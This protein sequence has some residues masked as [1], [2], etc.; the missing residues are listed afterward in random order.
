MGAVRIAAVLMAVSGLATPLPAQDVPDR[1]LPELDYQADRHDD[2]ETLEDEAADYDGRPRPW[3]ITPWIPLNWRS[4]LALAPQALRSGL[5][6]EPEVK[7]G[8]NWD[9]G[10]VRLLTEANAFVSVV[11]SDAVRNSSSWWLL[12]EA[13][14]GNAATAPA[15]YASYEPL[16]VYDGM[17]GDRILTFH[18]LTAGMRRQWGSTNLN[19]FLRRRDSTVDTLDRTVVAGQLSHTEALGHGMRFN[20]RTD[21]EARRYDQSGDTRRQDLFLR[22]RARLFIPLSPAADL[23]L[24]ADVQRNRSNTRDF[25]TTQVVIGPVLSA[26]FGL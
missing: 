17:F 7:L 5:A 10:G 24:N 8:R 2:A 14:T 22:V 3:S 19:L 23:V 20:I 1:P 4:N 21:A 16:T 25:V 9:L 6:F 15:P 12:A 13:A 18:T 11:P 26:S